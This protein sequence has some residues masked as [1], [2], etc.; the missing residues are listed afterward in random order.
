MGLVILEILDT[1]FQ[2]ERKNDIAITHDVLPYESSREITMRSVIATSD[3]IGAR[4]GARMC[5]ILDP[6][7]RLELEQ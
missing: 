1:A 2:A 4:V 3:A 7:S 6:L 5:E